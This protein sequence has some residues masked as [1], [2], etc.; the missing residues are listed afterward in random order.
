MKGCPKAHVLQH[1]THRPAM[2]RCADMLLAALGSAESDD[3]AGT[4]RVI[5]REETVSE[6]RGSFV[7]SPYA[8]GW[9]WRLRNTT[10]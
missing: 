7:A 1:P 4:L 6:A 3:G 10:P 2:C 5:L 8:V 9:R